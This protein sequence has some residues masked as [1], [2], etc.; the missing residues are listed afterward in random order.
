[1]ERRMREIPLPPIIKMRE[2]IRAKGKALSVIKEDPVELP[3][4]VVP[5]KRKREETTA[6]VHNHEKI[7][8][9][10]EKGR[11]V[12]GDGCHYEG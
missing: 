6:Q 3:Q 8:F 11:L 9:D 2:R 12:Y 7:K 1:M 5:G 10:V 4:T